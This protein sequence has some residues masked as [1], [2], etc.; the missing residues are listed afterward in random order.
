MLT[1]RKGNYE[2]QAEINISRH[3]EWNNH[4]KAIERTNAAVKDNQQYVK[5]NNLVRVVQLD[6]DSFNAN[7]R[8]YIINDIDY[9]TCSWEPVSITLNNGG[10]ITWG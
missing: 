1:T 9:T 5:D 8:R 6:S 4:R 2:I 7:N 10:Y 3:P